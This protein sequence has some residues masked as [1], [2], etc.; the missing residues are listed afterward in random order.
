MERGSKKDLATV[1]VDV[2]PG[3]AYILTGAA[4]GSTKACERRTVG[5][6]RCNCCWTHGV[7]AET[8]SRAG[9]HSM[10][11][12]A[13]AESDDESDGDEMDAAPLPIPSTVSGSVTTD[14]AAGS[15][16]TAGAKDDVSSL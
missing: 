10:T 12:R 11:L 15:V 16:T 6:G 7:R 5:H 14:G 8:A 13:L 1:S 9:R 4:Q 3:S 2:P